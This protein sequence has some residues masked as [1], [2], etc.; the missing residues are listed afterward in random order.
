MATP[1]GRQVPAPDAA[2]PTVHKG[3]RPAALN[4]A[5]LQVHGW[6]VH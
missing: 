4:R 3:R 6:Q 1:E 2:A 5:A